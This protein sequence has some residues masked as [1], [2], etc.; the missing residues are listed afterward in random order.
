LLINQLCAIK[1]HEND[2]DRDK[3]LNWLLKEDNPSVRLL[4]LTRLLNHPETDT[5]VQSAR[6]RLMDYSV[7]QGI[8]EYSDEIWQSGPRAFW[9]YK[10]KH[11]NTVYLGHFLANGHDPRIAEGVQALLEHRWAAGKFQCMTACM[12]TAFRRLG[13]GDHPTVIEGTETLAQR[14][15]SNG[16]IVCPGMN[17]SLLSR[18]YVVLP[19]LLLCF[20]EVPPRQRSPALQEAIDWITQELVDHQVYIYRP[21]NRKAWDAVRPKSRKHAD[22]P[23]G[24]TPETWR[25]KARARFLEENGIG[26]LEANTTWTRFGFPL[27]YNSDILEAMFALTTVDTPMSAGLD[28]PLKVILDKRGTDGLWRLEKSLNGQMWMDVEVKGKPSKW[29]TLFSLIVLDHFS[30]FSGSPKEK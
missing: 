10:G 17:N 8:L 6:A 20:G 23:E 12:L 19:K 2:M 14:F 24:E 27:N 25:D 7:T 22:C 21:G 9:S 26:E 18:C 30:A 15:L 16:G 3:T 4:T 1:A 13:Y 28:K 29:I 5:E 11:W